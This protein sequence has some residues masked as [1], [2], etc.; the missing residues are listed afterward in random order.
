MTRRRG[1]RGLLLLSLLV[2]LGLAGAAAAALGIAAAWYWHDLPP[3][4][5]VT[6]YRPRQHLQVLAADGSEIAAFGSERR[7]FVPLSQMPPQLVDAVLAIED[8]QFRDHFGI[9]LRGLLR[10]TLANLTGGMPQGASTLTQQ[11]ARTFFLSTRRTPERKIKEALLALQ[12]ERQLSK[13]QILELYLNQIYLGQRAYGFGAAAMTYFGKPVAA[14]TLAESAMLAGLPQNPIWANPVVNAERA[15]RRQ[16]LVLGR[17]KAIGRIDAAQHERALAEPLVL[18]DARTPTLHAEHVAEMARLAVVQRF[19]ADAYTEGLR[20]HTTL[21]PADQRAAHAALRRALVARERSLPWRGPEDHDE[22]P[23]TLA[24]AELERA[25]AQALKDRRDDDELRVAIVLEASPQELRVQL[26]G[27]EALRITGNGLRQARPGLAPRAPAA[28]ALR[29]GSIVRVVADGN[30]WAVTQ[31]PEAEGAFVALDPA[32][33]RVRALVGGFDF[34]EAAFNHVT[35]AWRQPGSALKPFVYAAAFEQGLRPETVVDDA[36]LAPQEGGDAGWAPKNADGRFDG[37]ITL[38][39]AMQRSRNLVSIRVLRHVGVAAA[40]AA[41]ARFGFDPARHPDNA[42]LALGSGSVTPL[43]LA[44]AYAALANG[45]RRVTPLLIERVVDS[46]GR[47]LFEA[48]PTA[49]EPALDPARAFLVASLLADVTQQGTAARAGAQLRRSDI[50]GKTGTTNEA[51]DAWF[52]GWHEQVAAV[53]WIG[54]DEPRSLGDQASGGGLALPVWIDYMAQVLPLLPPR[55]LQPPEGVTRGERDWRLADDRDEALVLRI[56]APV[57][58]AP[59][60]TAEPAA[61]A[62]SR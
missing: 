39:E 11:V 6:D 46:R 50:A 35:Q 42:T 45:G 8:T 61:S 57:P 13:D 47:V 5:K 10:A 1:A 58:D 37:P 62:A 3:L 21:Q 33:G 31:W 44:A 29:R 34:R 20:V 27:G 14:L 32:S 59:G 7:I 24:G 41:L 18:R 9:S 54:Y 19:G 26:A 30:G 55:P 56:A 51:V 36:P 40:K 28:L 25:A 16:Q 17:M 15:R 49:P 43:Q 52:A 38:R 48:T 23:A 12:I 60:A 53:A 4:T 2:L 22:L